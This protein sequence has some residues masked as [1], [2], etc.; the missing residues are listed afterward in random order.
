[1]V[2][3]GATTSN[4]CGALNSVNLWGE[5]VGVHKRYWAFFQI[6]PYLCRSFRSENLV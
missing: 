1:V 6:Y 4:R 2:M 3:S 5:G